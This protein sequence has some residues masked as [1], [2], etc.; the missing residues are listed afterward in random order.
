[1]NERYWQ[2]VPVGKEN[3]KTY[4]EL[5]CMWE[6][7]KRTVRSILHELSRYD[8]GDDYILIRSSNGKGFYK[9]DDVAEIEAYK[10]ECLS[11][12]RNVF[13]PIKKI[14]RVL[15]TRGNVQFSFGN[16]LRVIREGAGMKQSKVCEQ[17]KKYDS[18]FNVPMLSKMENGCVL[19]TPYQRF[20]LAQIYGCEPS[21]LVSADLY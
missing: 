15:N 14:N 1:M 8:S 2:D 11:R 5:C 13:A 16:N 9:T 20:L 7:D 3:A 19:P 12:G 6:K 4:D 18:S 17:I 21:D 10:K